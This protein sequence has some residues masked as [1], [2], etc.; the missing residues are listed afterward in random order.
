M[1][2]QFFKKTS[3]IFKYDVYIILL[4]GFTILPLLV[5][6]YFNQPSA[7]DYCYAAKAQSL[8]FWN[9]QIDFYRGWSGRYL[10]TALLSFDILVKGKIIL[11]KLFPIALILLLSKSVFNLVSL[12]FTSISKKNRYVITSLFI[13]AYFVQMPNISEGLFWYAGSVTYQLSNI[14]SVL[15]ICSLISLLR[16]KKVK[17]LFFAIIYV[18]LLI[19]T[20]ETTM[21]MWA[22]TLAFIFLYKAIL[23]KKIS[24]HLILIIIIVLTFSLAVI[25]APGNSVRGAFFSESHQFFNSIFQSL[26]ALVINTIK[27]A[28]LLCLLTVLFFSNLKGNVGIVSSKILKANP[29]L[30]FLVVCMVSFLGFFISFWSM[31]NAPPSRTVNVICFYFMLGFLY[32]MFL[33]FIKFEKEIVLL[34]LINKKVKYV[35]MFIVLG[36]IMSFNN[37]RGVYVDLLSGTAYLYNLEMEERY[38]IIQNNSSMILSIPSLKNKPVTLFVS[39]ISADPENWR[40]ECYGAYF[41]EKVI[42]IKKED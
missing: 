28:P 3:F 24:Y 18:I 27:W 1:I 32:T 39:D 10:S 14:I 36:S 42:V 34:K 8:G 40:N 38:Q 16:Y 19:G 31:G 9:A 12:V 33:L 22:V 35:L 5:I 26:R 7:D 2:K 41:S 37:I 13:T 17:H 4:G 21:I 6:S 23:D 11:Y 15:L 30:V 20:N 29:F 25:L